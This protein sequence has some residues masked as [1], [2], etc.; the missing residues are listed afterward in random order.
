VRKVS[1]LTLGVVLLMTGCADEA[2]QKRAQTRDDVNKALA[3]LKKVDAGYVPKGTNVV[4]E[5]DGSVLEAYQVTSNSKAADDLRKLVPNISADQKPSVLLMIANTDMQ[6]ALVSSRDARIEGARIC[7]AS[8]GLIS[9][10]ASAANSQIQAAAFK[11]SLD[12]STTRDLDSLLKTYQSDLEQQKALADKLTKDSQALQAQVQALGDEADKLNAGVRQMRESA[13]VKT[14][15]AQL[16]LYKKAANIEI[17]A[18]K[19]QTKR[20]LKL[21]ARDLVVSQLKLALANQQSLQQSVDTLQA[22]VQQSQSR[23]KELDAKVRSLESASSSSLAG[24]LELYNELEAARTSKVEKNFDKARTRAAAAVASA[25]EAW[26]ASQGKGDQERYYKLEL[27]GKRELYIDIMV[28]Q[29]AFEQDYTETLNLVTKYGADQGVP[30]SDT[31]L[32][33]PQRYAKAQAALAPVAWKEYRAASA[34]VTELSTGQADEAG[35]VTAQAAYSR[36]QALEKSLTQLA[37]EGTAA[38]P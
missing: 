10:L 9:R 32:Q 19:N 28:Q 35:V 38:A 12:G 17:E 33:G 21:V 31:L 25:E 29:L 36:L 26:K 1:I 27:L 23:S 8:V 15:N 2:A 34:L 5:E 11:K 4:P 24:V 7:S 6:A 14:G 20:Q 30:V 18:Q 16:D 3:E 37:P 22:Q 13:F